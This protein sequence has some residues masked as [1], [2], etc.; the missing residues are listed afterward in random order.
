MAA[1]MKFFGI[2]SDMK[3]AVRVAL[4]LAA[5][6]VIGGGAYCAVASAARV[7]QN[8]GV[9]IT[10]DEMAELAGSSETGG[11][12]IMRWERAPQ[13]VANSHGHEFRVVKRMDM[14][15][16]ISITKGLYYL[17]D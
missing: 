12:S 2:I 7:L 9:E 10:M 11:T 5:A 8:Y 13:R 14:A 4:A 3:G 15:D 1:K 16:A 6:V 17:P